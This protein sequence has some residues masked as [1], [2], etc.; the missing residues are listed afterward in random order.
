MTWRETCSSEYIRLYLVHGYR[1]V[2][3]RSSHVH[4]QPVGWLKCWLEFR[5][6]LW[7]RPKFIL[8]LKVWFRLKLGFVVQL[9]HRKGAVAV[10]VSVSSM[11]R[12]AASVGPFIL[13]GTAND[14]FGDQIDDLADTEHYAECRSS[15]HEVSED[16]FLCGSANVTVHNVGTWLDVTLHQSWQVEAVVDVMEDVQEGDL[17]AGLDKKADQVRPPQSA[18]LL[19]SVVVELSFFAMLLTV[20]AFALVT[21][22]HMHDDH[23]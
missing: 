10:L 19:P 3:S 5:F 9:M 18:V 4:A 8:T 13:A 23:Q 6:K 7:F 14:A 12:C 22:L 2:W 16:S 1:E 15:D 17:D 11:K 20:L 21:V